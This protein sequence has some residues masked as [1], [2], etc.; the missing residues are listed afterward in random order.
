VYLEKKNLQNNI[1][2]TQ[3]HSFLKVKWFGLDIDH[4]QA[5][6][7]ITKS[8]VRINIHV[9]IIIIIVVI[10]LYVGSYSFKIKL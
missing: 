6:Y 8:Q 5:K 3:L 1:S 4:H 10:M 2:L 9:I 7:T